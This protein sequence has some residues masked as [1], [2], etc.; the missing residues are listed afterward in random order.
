[1]KNTT[2]VLLLLSCFSCSS[3]ATTTVA[4]ENITTAT[5]AT[6]MELNGFKEAIKHVHYLAKVTITDVEII[7]EDDET[8][9]HL[10]FANVLATYRGKAHKTI[11]YE[12][13][14]EKG[15][16]SIIGNAPVYIALCKDNQG[17]YY[18]P[19][20]GSQ[21]SSSETINNWLTENVKAVLDMSTTGN[22][23]D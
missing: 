21:F 2:L 15:E 10:Y 19:G 7:S 1:M 23:C 5:D 20:T 3:I 11:S 9:K 8:D 17:T 4:A 18:W 14:V 22:W 13:F 6:N 12:M 16:E